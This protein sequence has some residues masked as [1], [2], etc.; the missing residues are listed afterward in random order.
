MS[1]QSSPQPVPDEAD[2]SRGP[3]G[4]R[5]GPCG[6]SFSRLVGRTG[7]VTRSPTLTQPMT[8]AFAA[9][10]PP[11]YA[12]T[13]AALVRGEGAVGWVR[14]LGLPARFL[15]ADGTLVLT[16]GWPRGEAA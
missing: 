11:A 2:R 4:R 5:P 16:D 14:D 13:T 12:V 10:A 9:T 15:R 1:D 7:W 3:G 6:A 8:E